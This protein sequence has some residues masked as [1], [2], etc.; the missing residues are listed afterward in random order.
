MERVWR[1]GDA[2]ALIDD[3]MVPLMNHAQKPIARALLGQE[4]DANAGDH[5]GP[6]FAWRPTPLHAMLESARQ[7]GDRFDLGPTVST[8]QQV[9]DLVGA[10]LDPA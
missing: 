8:L 9:A 7:L 4:I 3:A 10:E 6:A 1:E 5:A 2:S